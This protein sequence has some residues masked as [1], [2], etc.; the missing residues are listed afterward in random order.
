ML[1]IQENLETK[2]AIEDAKT[3]ARRAKRQKEKEKKRN[4]KRKIQASEEEW[5]TKDEAHALQPDLD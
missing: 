3:A 2:N 4:K 5:A 1:G